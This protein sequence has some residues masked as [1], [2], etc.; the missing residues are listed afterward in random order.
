[1]RQEFPD[2]L[3][4]VTPSNS[5]GTPFSQEDFIPATWRGISSQ[6]FY[7]GNGASAETLESSLDA[8][9]RSKGPFGAVYPPI[10]YSMEGDTP[11]WFSLVNNGLNSYRNPSWGG[12]GGR[13][14][15]RIFYGE[16]RPI[17]TQGFTSSD[18]VTGIE[19]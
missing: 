8:N 4:I 18:T 9:I 11:S 13:Y 16:S 17:W 10:Q 1:M 15:W 6:G 14:E 2:L 5:Y 12:W 3:Y 19:R 7:E